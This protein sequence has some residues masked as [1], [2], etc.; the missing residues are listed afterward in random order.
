MW[1]NRKPVFATG[2]MKKGALCISI[3][4]ELAWGVWDQLTPGYVRQCV[5]LER[6]IVKRILELFVGALPRTSSAVAVLS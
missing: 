2:E 3:D 1:R 6:T 4:L 5:E